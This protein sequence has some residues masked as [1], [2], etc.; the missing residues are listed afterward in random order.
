MIPHRG[1]TYFFERIF[2]WSWRLILGNFLRNIAL[3]C[4]LKKK[5][6]LPEIWEAP[7]RETFFLALW[8]NLFLPAFSR[9]FSRNKMLFRYPSERDIPK[10][11]MGV[12]GQRQ[13]NIAWCVG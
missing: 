4:C 6:I 8:Q 5:R 9:S 1:V 10:P 12:R 2:L 7:D 11:S 13:M 3:Y